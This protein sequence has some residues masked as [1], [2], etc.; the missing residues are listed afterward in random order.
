MAASLYGVTNS[1]IRGANLSKSAVVGK[2]FFSSISRSGIVRLIPATK[3]LKAKAVSDVVATAYAV[4]AAWGLGKATGKASLQLT[5]M[6][7][8]INNKTDPKCL[9]RD[10]SLLGDVWESFTGGNS[11]YSRLEALSASV[12]SL[13]YYTANKL[14]ILNNKYIKNCK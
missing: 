13:H 11:T 2:S 7:S 5:K 14:T 4:A 10:R 9:L 3:L 1:A 12:D 8:S 6:L